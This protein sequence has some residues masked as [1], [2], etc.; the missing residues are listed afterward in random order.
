[1]SNR[2][3][4][5]RRL[6]DK[7]L[8]LQTF[9]KLASGCFDLAN[10]ATETRILQVLRRGE[11]DLHNLRSVASATCNLVGQLPQKQLQTAMMYSMHGNIET[12]SKALE[13]IG[14]FVKMMSALLQANP[15]SLGE[16]QSVVKEG[17]I[18]VLKCFEGIYDEARMSVVNDAQNL[19]D[20]ATKIKDLAGDSNVRELIHR[21][22]DS[23]KL[24][25]SLSVPKTAEEHRRSLSLVS[26]QIERLSALEERVEQKASELPPG[27]KKDKMEELRRSTRRQRNWWK[28][29]EI[30]LS[31]IGFVFAGVVTT[32]VGGVYLTDWFHGI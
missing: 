7:G 1:M 18:G 31:A 11:E 20:E 27:P 28:V 23:T 21:I 25:E 8:E 9:N 16:F 32:A 17:A 29:I 13:G 22:Q 3:D 26:N 5:D 6:Q 14:H 24:L 19:T 12:A 4:N 2:A 30:L 10:P 15:D